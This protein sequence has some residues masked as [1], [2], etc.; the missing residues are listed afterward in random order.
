MNQKLVDADGMGMAE[1]WPLRIE[2]AQRQTTYTIGGKVCSR[3][4]YGDER[5]NWG[6]DKQ[7]C[8]DCAVTKGQLHVP[9][10]DVERCPVC[11]GQAISCDCPYEEEVGA[12]DGK[13]SAND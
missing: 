2:E 3:I 6:A 4:R 9:G 11:K 8:H 5:L 7:P 13:S 10:C 1:G 12:A